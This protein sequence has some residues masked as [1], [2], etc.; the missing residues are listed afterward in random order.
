M[1]QLR[2]G[3]V[4]ETQQ[5]AEPL[6]ALDRA[7]GRH[8]TIIAFNQA[9]VEPLVIPLRV[10]QPHNTRPTKL[11]FGRSGIPGIRCLAVKS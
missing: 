4:V 1:N 7:E 10:V 9:V 3:T 11:T 8:L 6:D 2:S 5:P